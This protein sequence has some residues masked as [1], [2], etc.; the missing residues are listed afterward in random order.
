MHVYP[1]LMPIATNDRNF[2][3]LGLFFGPWYA[4]VR[5]SFLGSE[6][7]ESVLALDIR[8]KEKLLA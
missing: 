5:K 6:V 8:N 4:V 1:G 7:L 3:I 2:R